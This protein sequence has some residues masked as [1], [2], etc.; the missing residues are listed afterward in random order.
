MNIRTKILVIFLLTSIPAVSIV[1]AINYENAKNRITND[2]LEKLD[3]IATVQEKRVEESIERNFERLEGITSRTQLR[4]SLDQFN[5]NGNSDDKEKIQAIIED[6]KNSIRDIDTVFI[7]NPSGEVIFST[8]KS[9]IGKTM[10]SDKTFVEGFTKNTLTYGNNI[11][12]NSPELC[13]SGPL[14][15]NGET[16]GV[17]VIKVDP[18]TLLDISSDYT[19]LGDTGETFLGMRFG[20]GDAI[21]ITPLRFDEN[22]I[23]NR[24]ILKE[25]TEIPIIH[26]LDKHE[27]ILLNAIDYRG[28][29]VLAATRYIESTDWGLVVKID[30]DEA[31]STI[32]SIRDTTLISLGVVL[33][34]T[35]IGS[36]FFS[37][38]FTSRIKKLSAATKE[39]A[40]GELKTQV[41]T[42]GDDEVG[43]LSKDIQ[44]M[45]K[46]LRDNKLKLLNETR[47][48]AIGELSARIA[49]DLRNPLSV[50]KNSL[51]LMEYARRDVLSEHE[52][53]QF[54]MMNRAVERME[55]QITEV[56][57]FVRNRDILREEVDL[58][59]LLN[60]TVSSFDIPR[61]VRLNL[62]NS[63][64]MISV[65][66]AQIQAVFSNVIQNALHAVGQEGEIG[67]NF[68]K[69]AENVK[70]TIKDSGT[71]IPQENIE[72][73]FEPLFTTKQTGTGLGLASCKNIIEKH[74]GTISFS[75]NPTTFTIT[76]PIGIKISEKKN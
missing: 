48:A 67:V 47:F 62:P 3:G 53:R 34:A 60:L 37:K 31:F 66:S 49:H 43:Q 9:I 4:F 61:D 19:S 65:D 16:L 57:D 21:F 42:T 73:I 8:E 64:V 54:S 56:L 18:K 6:A 10:S 69:D 39:I 76:L 51:E 2:V 58:L 36:V 52:K 15:L 72:K 44:T 22:A 28:E 14:I 33:V 30:T 32:N 1:G 20:D 41:T 55:R 75:N 27:E 5:Q 11:L 13:I 40:G 17:L 35:I 26:A 68:E 46:A 70:I 50:V 7:I 45:E 24:V 74:G 71:G 59:D 29:A 63:G 38:T 25:Q 12:D 23:L